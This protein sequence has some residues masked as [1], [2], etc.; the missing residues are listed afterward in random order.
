MALFRKSGVLETYKRVPLLVVDDLGK[1]KATDW[2]ISTLYSIIDGRYDRAMP[3][4]ITTNYDPATLVRRL[5]PKGDYGTTAE[6]I[7]D[8]INEMCK[9]LITTG[10]SWRSK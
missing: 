6:C 9:V 1:E 5:S 10:E 4:I 2:T 8:R 7:I 3:L